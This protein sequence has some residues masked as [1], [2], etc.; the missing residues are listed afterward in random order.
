MADST[1]RSFVPLES[2][3][4]SVTIP[5]PSVADRLLA[6]LSHHRRRATLTALSRTDAPMALDD[7]ATEVARAE[8][9]SA[10]AGTDAETVRAVRLSLHHAHVP[11]LADAG[12]VR[13]DRERRTVSLTEALG[14]NERTLVAHLEHD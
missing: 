4:V 10:S 2:L 13:Y 5:D 1:V 7:L 11:Q 8:T 12:L 3:S 6:T 9:S 14:Q